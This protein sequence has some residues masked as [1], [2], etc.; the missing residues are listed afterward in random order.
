MPLGREVGLV[1]N[2]IVLDGDPA[3]PKKGATHSS[4][5]FSAHIHCGQ[6]AGWMKMPNEDATWYGDRP[7]P[8]PHCV[9]WEDPALPRK[10]AQ[11][12]PLFGPNGGPSQQLHAEFL[13]LLFTIV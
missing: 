9:R 3:P 6:T 11:Q 5:H 13:L 12:P 2:D 8:R 4:P 10:W 7:R 1:P